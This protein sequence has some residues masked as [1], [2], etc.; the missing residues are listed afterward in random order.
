MRPSLALQGVAGQS[1]ALGGPTFRPFAEIARRL[2]VFRPPR[3]SVLIIFSYRVSVLRRSGFAVN[4]D[5]VALPVWISYSPPPSSCVVTPVL[6]AE[7]TASREP[8]LVFG[9]ALSAARPSPVVP[10]AL[11]MSP[12]ARHLS[13]STPAALTVR[14]AIQRLRRSKEQEA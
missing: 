5:L 14:S 4:T 6:S 8:V 12:S 11:S 13:R 10:G 2:P 9:P 7:R 1:S 3:S